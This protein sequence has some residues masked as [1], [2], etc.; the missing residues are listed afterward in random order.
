TA[1]RTAELVGLEF[2]G[3]LYANYAF[4]LLWVADVIWWWRGLD[5]YEA[6]PCSLNWAVLG[7]LG[8]MAFN[9]TIVFGT[10]TVRWLGLGGCLVLGT[11]GGVRVRRSKR[12][13]ASA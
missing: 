12:T 2:G 7:F 10:Q 4:T 11:I 6:R 3:G 1:Q 13:A 5:R 9:A 8:F